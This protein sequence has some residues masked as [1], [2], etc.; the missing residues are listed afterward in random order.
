[1]NPYEWPR[2]TLSSSCVPAPAIAAAGANGLFTRALKK[3]AMDDVLK[4]NDIS[5]VCDDVGL[6][7]KP[8][9]YCDDPLLDE[10]PFD[11]TIALPIK[12]EAIQDILYGFAHDNKGL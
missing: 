12:I 5:I 6:L 1:M 11:V 9:T 3:S 4:S 2:E 8:T 10:L 7:T